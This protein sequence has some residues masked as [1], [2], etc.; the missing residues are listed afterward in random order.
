M[1]FARHPFA[2]AVGTVVGL[3]VALAYLVHPPLPRSVLLVYM[4]I[5]VIAVLLYASFDDARWEE[6]KRPIHAAFRD[7][8]KWPIRGVFLVIVPSLVAFLAYSG[9]APSLNPPV[10]LRQAH[11]A[12]PSRLKAFDKSYDLLKLENP[13]RAQV[14]ELLKSDPEKAGETYAAAVEAG[15][16]I[17]FQNC[18][19][20]HGD[21]LNG[22]GM[23][24][25]GLNPRPADFR[26]VGT[27]AQLQES[28]LFWRITTGGPGLPAEGAP[29]NSA[30]PVWGEMLSEKDV[31]NVITFLY[32]HVGQ[33][34]RMWNQKVSEAVAS[35]RD[36]AEAERANM[37]GPQL[38]QFHCA[39]CHGEEGAGDGPAAQFL[40]PAPRDFTIGLFKYKT[41]PVKTIPPT[42]D[43]LFLIIKNGL[44]GTGM[45]AWGSLLSDAQ[46]RSLAPVLKGFDT[47]GT[48]APRDAPDS[49]FDAAG[50]YVKKPLSIAEQFSVENAVPFTEESVAKGKVAFERTCAQCHGADGR[51]DPAPDKRLK[52]E[53]GN[54]IWPRDLTKPWTWRVTN[55]ADSVEET[56]RNIYVRLSEGIPG[57]PMPAHADKVIEEDRWNI[58]NYVYT[59]RNYTPP[60]SASQ[61]IQGLKVVGPLPDSVNGSAWT[62]APVTTLRV[63]P[64]IMKGNRLFKPLTDALSVRV[65][66]NDDEIA[67]LLEMDDRTYSR[68]GDPDAESTQ[69]KALELYPD[70]FAIQLPRQDAFVT[71]PTVE[72]P[73]FRHGDP[74]H[75][76]VIWYWNAG[77]VEPNVAPNTIIFDAMG[78]DEKM[79]PR[80]DDT[81]VKTFGEWTNGRWRV[82]MKR[83]RDAGGSGDLTFTEG[84]FFPV[85][86]ANWDGSN[87]ERGAKHTLSSWYWL[88][89]PPPD[90]P[91][92]TYGVPLAAGAV[93]FGL[94]LLL[95][96]RE[97]SK[98]AK[99]SS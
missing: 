43:D 23:F 48:W 56:I 80:E 20:C 58:A 78:V 53:W 44:S 66:Y 68:P 84:K 4:L 72:K 82:M 73:L 39:A 88:L 37:D 52:D 7:D 76:T 36:K 87:G 29:W 17:Y 49:D 46:I 77:S 81:S 12:P 25:D 28:Y 14:L 21:L 41:S 65:L 40:Y 47:V 27:I 71:D 59:L 5:I 26:D 6:F 98:A 8:N 94:G 9:V 38:Y 62:S 64:N 51:G 33:V 18:F 89:L 32:D 91:V 24:A 50:H 95:I 69:D 22:R 55:V 86:F 35:M 85:S 42:D 93:T 99:N 19:Y 83:R 63:I 13:V 45:P 34:P 54:R 15:K 2:Y 30:M 79:H 1:R 11:T 67:F 90:N 61:V 10:E 16:N 92:K 97:R 57:T 96:R 74:A 3:Y 75:P 31:W 60:L 70:A